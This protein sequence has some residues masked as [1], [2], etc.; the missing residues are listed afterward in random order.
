METEN[1]LSLSLTIA[2]YAETE[3]GSRT[4]VHE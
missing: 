2:L 1:K 3:N 4:V